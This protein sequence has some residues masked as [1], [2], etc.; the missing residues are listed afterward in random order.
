MY[1]VL[2]GSPSEGFRVVGPFATFEDAR[3]WEKSNL[4]STPPVSFM[5]SW[6]MIMETPND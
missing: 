2:I 1:I 3:A 4:S 6:V 5:H